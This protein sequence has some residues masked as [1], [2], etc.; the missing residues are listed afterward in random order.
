MGLNF[1]L[2]SPCAVSQQ[3]PPF[4]RPS[5]RTRKIPKSVVYFKRKECRLVCKLIERSMEVDTPAKLTGF[6][7]ENQRDKLGEQP[8]PIEETLKVQSV[9]SSSQELER[10]SSNKLTNW[11]ARAK[12]TCQR[13]R[14][15]TATLGQTKV[16]QGRKVQASSFRRMPSG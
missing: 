8:R 5:T 11:L 14:L 16:T 9:A 10:K 1:G 13:K 3:Q 7:Q 2:S 15:R 4:G 12:S 6:S